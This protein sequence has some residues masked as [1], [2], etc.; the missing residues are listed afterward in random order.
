MGFQKFFTFE[1]AFELQLIF[2]LNP[3]GFFYSF[4][5]YIEVFK[6]LMTLSFLLGT[7]ENFQSDA[8][9]GSHFSSL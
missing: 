4:E 2:T 3:R 6:F 8:C 7:L 1:I 9:R 5:T